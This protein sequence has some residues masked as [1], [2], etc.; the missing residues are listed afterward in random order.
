MKYLGLVIAVLLVTLTGCTD[1]PDG[2]KTKISFN[3][4][5]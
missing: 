5:L 1:Y 4:G 2:E 3:H